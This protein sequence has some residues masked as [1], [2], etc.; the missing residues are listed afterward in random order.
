MHRT[1]KHPCPFGGNALEVLVDWED[2]TQINKLHTVS[3]SGDCYGK[4]K[5]G[6]RVG[7]VKVM[8][9]EAILYQVVQENLNT[10]VDI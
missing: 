1:E 4:A 7:S 3:E 8:R 10:N 9:R 6:P 2:S 5:V